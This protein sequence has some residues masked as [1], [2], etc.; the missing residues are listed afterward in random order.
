MGGNQCH[1]E[2]ES[3]QPVDDEI[4]AA[5]NGNYMLGKKRYQEQIAQALERRVTRG[6]AGRPAK[7]GLMCQ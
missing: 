1:A 7:E 2:R 6:K 4:R 5:T 3:D